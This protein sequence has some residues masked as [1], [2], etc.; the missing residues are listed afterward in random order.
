MKAS[1][2]QCPNAGCFIQ[3]HCSK[4]WLRRIEEGKDLH[5][6]KAGQ[7]ILFEGSSVTGIYFIYSG[8]VKVFK[9]QEGGKNYQIVR[10]SKAG[11]ILGHRGYGN[12]MKYPVSAGALT[13]CRLCFIPNE[14]FLTALKAN[15][16]LAYELMM[17]Y[18]RELSVAESK[19]YHYVRMPVKSRVAD[20]VLG[21]AR[22]CGFQKNDPKKIAV[23]VSRRDIA[24]MAAT[25]YE[26]ALRVL[27]EF[28]DKD[29][30]AYEGKYIRILNLGAIETISRSALE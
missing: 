21:L 7:R 27:T 13:D 19:M 18:A 10:L 3:Q 2:S 12:D 22:I 8:N 23:P 9:G 14:V 25:A 17:F 4:D 30:L 5:E 24:N 1:C 26:T 20:V 6:V 29:I 16:K 11:D 15:E 28:G